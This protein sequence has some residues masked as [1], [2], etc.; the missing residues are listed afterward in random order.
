MPF[1]PSKG[2]S[3]KGKGGHWE[4]V[5]AHVPAL[6]P[7]C[8]FQYSNTTLMHLGRSKCAPGLMVYAR[9]VFPAPRS[10]QPAFPSARLSQGQMTS[11]SVVW[12]PDS[13]APVSSESI[14]QGPLSV[15][16]SILIWKKLATF[17][18]FS[19]GSCCPMSPR[20]CTFPCET[21]GHLGE[22]LA[23]TGDAKQPRLRNLPRDRA[24]RV[25]GGALGWP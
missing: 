7:I 13:P 1:W 16:I 4:S 19:L 12:S 23:N 14:R 3:G 24:A 5:R 21:A 8:S 18:A 17:L 22:S 6:R 10:A 15:G 25:L 20:G 11:F 9:T 2:K